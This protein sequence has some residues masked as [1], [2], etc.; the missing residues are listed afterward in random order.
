VNFYPDC[1]LIFILR[2]SMLC[3]LIGGYR[4]LLLLLWRIRLKREFPDPLN[5]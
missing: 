2:R 4:D 5:F 1:G 3:G